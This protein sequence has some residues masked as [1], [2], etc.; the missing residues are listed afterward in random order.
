MWS[1]RCDT[2]EM[3]DMRDVIAQMWC[4]RDVRR[5]DLAGRNCGKCCVFHS[6]V[7]SLAGKVIS[8]ERAGAEDRLLKMCQNLHHACA[9]ERFG[10]QNCSELRV[11]EHFWKLKIWMILFW[12]LWDKAECKPKKKKC[13]TKCKRGH[14][15]TKKQRKRRILGCCLWVGN[16][17]Y[18]RIQRKYR[19]RG[20]KKRYRLLLNMRIT[21]CVSKLAAPLWAT[22]CACLF[23]VGFREIL[24]HHW[25]LQCCHGAGTLGKGAELAKLPTLDLAAVEQRKEKDLN[26]MKP[27]RPKTPNWP[28]LCFKSC[29]PTKMEQNTIQL[30]KKG[31]SQQK[32]KGRYPQN[33]IRA[34]LSPIFD[35]A[36]GSRNH[37]SLVWPPSGRSNVRQT[38]QICPKMWCGTFSSSCQP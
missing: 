21:I 4:S 23:T 6:F 22:T 11:R 17:R 34:F 16:R 18:K 35:A 8:W 27:V 5:E 9:R 30:K 14:K 36:A 7:A 32:R 38:E 2:A 31:S 15:K 19:L 12:L 13:W 3:W 37:Q 26:N 20:Q 24:K 1:R 33:P 28:N 10:S 25:R 29:N